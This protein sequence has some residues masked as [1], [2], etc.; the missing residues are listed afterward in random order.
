M[1]RI[2]KMTEQNCK[3]CRFSNKTHIPLMLGANILECRRY[4]PRVVEVN[5]PKFPY[6]QKE[7]WCGEW[8][9]KEESRNQL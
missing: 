5:L 3:N 6:M 1:N 8:Q 7:V 2:D 4:P 9:S